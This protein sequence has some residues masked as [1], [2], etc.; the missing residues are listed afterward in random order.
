M[1]PKLRPALAA[2]LLTLPAWAGSMASVSLNVNEGGCSE[3]A[4]DDSSLSGMAVAYFYASPLCTHLPFSSGSASST[5][6]PGFIRMSAD[7]DP[8]YGGATYYAYM[9]AQ[10]MWTVFIPG[11]Q[12]GW[13][14]TTI[15]VAGVG[16][17][18]GERW[19][20]SG[21]GFNFVGDPFPCHSDWCE[22]TFSFLSDPMAIPAD[23]QSFLF[24]IAGNVG[25]YDNQSRPVVRS[26]SLD[27]QFHPMPEPASGALLLI[28]TIGLLLRRA[29]HKS[30][31]L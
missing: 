11:P 16:A 25:V 14:E 9:E 1:H 10:S 20:F 19:G 30:S 29:S 7:I 3:I 4:H 27:V 18:T 12:V 22:Q 26:A 8:G 5:V 15:T 17:D 21:P 24:S 28:G 6:S 31:K 13:F 2:L 23:G